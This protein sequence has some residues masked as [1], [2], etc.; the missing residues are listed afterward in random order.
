MNEEVYT[1]A[2]KSALT[3][4]QNSCQ[5]IKH[6]FLFTKDGTM[7]SG[8]NDTTI[9]PELAKAA[10]SFQT[11]AEKAGAIGGLNQ[12]LID[13]D[14]GKVY[15]STIKNMY[16]LGEI[17]KQA[18]IAYI[19]SITGI[20]FPTIL[21][22]L[23]NISGSIGEVGPTP[24]K[25]LPSKPLK[26]ETVKEKGKD[27]AKPAK[28]ETKKAKTP[29][30]LPSVSPRRLIVNPL[31]GLFVRTDIVQVDSQV[32]K[33]WSTLIGGKEI[34]ELEIE[35]FNGKKAQYKVK[36]ISDRR[37]QDKGFIRIP[38]KTCQT[39]KLNKGELVQVKPVL[40][41]K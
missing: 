35:T 7:I 32:L 16:F 38:E 9:D 20:V 1:I 13:G 31:G 4:I 28:E 36:T 34:T 15:V 5:E 8:N 19:R 39:L 27:F 12:L 25:S 3:E 11:L 23:E 2:L 10:S 17:S 14:K 21:R 26:D 18:D 40:H 37:L 22:V 24:L 33:Q 6:S 30:A 41:K 29:E